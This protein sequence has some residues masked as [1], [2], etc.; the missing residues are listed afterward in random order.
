MWIFIIYFCS[1][2][3]GEKGGDSGWQQVRC[4]GSWSGQV[5]GDHL[6]LGTSETLSSQEEKSFGHTALM[7]NMSLSCWDIS[8]ISHSFS[9]DLL[10]V[11]N[12][13]LLFKCV[14]LISLWKLDVVFST[15]EVLYE[16][17]FDDSYSKVSKVLKNLL[18]RSKSHVFNIQEQYKYMS[19]KI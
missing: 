18:I 6:V 4:P 11:S 2:T 1:L 10:L 3:R 8:N 13:L 19:I 5:R 15:E 17:M 9:F 7:L 16:A 14:Y 12:S